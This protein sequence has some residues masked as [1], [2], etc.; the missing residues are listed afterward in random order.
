MMKETI[1]DILGIPS[2]TNQKEIKHAYA[3]CA[4]KVHPEEHPE[5]F[6]RLNE[7]YRLALQY[8][9]SMQKKTTQATPV[10]KAT[11]DNNTQQILHNSFSSSTVLPHEEEVMQ[12]QELLEKAKQKQEEKYKEQRD[13]VWNQLKTMIED[14]RTSIDTWTLYLENKPFSSI[15]LDPVFLSTLAE[16]LQ[17]YDTIPLYANLALTNYYKTIQ[18]PL[19]HEFG[20]PYLL[21]IL[22][23]LN[24]RYEEHKKQK[25]KKLYKIIT[26][27]SIVLCIIVS[28][29]GILTQK[30]EIA[31][32]LCYIIAFIAI[33]QNAGK[34]ELDK[35]QRI[36]LLVSIILLHIGFAILFGLSFVSQSETKK[37]SVIYFAQHQYGEQVVYETK[38]ERNEALYPNEEIYVFYD[39]DKDFNFHIKVYEQDNHYTFE[40]DYASTLALSMNTSSLIHPYMKQDHDNLLLQDPLYHGITVD[41]IDHDANT[42]MKELYEFLQLAKADQKLQALKQTVS[43]YAMPQSATYDTWFH[44][45]LS[46]EEAFAMNEEQLYDWLAYSDTIYR[47]DFTLLEYDET[48][49]YVQRYLNETVGIELTYQGELKHIDGIRSENNCLSIGNFYRLAKALDLDVHTTFD[50]LAW[51]INGRIQYIGS[52]NVKPY[53]DIDLIEELLNQS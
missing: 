37:D 29:I 23:Q 52:N 1:W 15:A 2:T 32:L 7:A 39:E 43:I 9:K 20:L 11:H 4:K 18:D 50:G 47:M 51:K 22:D 8:A 17:A 13:Q 42:S 53:I 16:Q 45:T 10:T 31:I 27:L 25:N 41:I 33:L 44:H 35:A 40:D 34:K 21:T 38:Q 24:T 19:L 46:L 28:L 30:M 49:P 26:I 12:V 48:D 14:K 6:M 5:E 3:K 36:R